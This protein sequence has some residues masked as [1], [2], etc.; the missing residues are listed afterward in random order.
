[1]DSFKKVMSGLALASMLLAGCTGMAAP[2]LTLTEAPSETPSAAPSTTAPTVIP[3]PTS[4]ATLAL[5]PT[6]TPNPEFSPPSIEL[7][8]ALSVESAEGRVLESVCL[9]TNATYTVAQTQ[10]PPPLDEVTRETLGAMGVEVRDPGQSCDADLI[11]HWKLTA[12]SDKYER[13][14][15]Y[16]TCFT[17][18]D[19]K[20]DVVLAIGETRLSATHAAESQ[21]KLSS[22]VC[23]QAD[24]V[25]FQE[26]WPVIIT[27]M[28]VN[29][30][31]TPSLYA[32]LDAP[33]MEH[34][35]K[36][37]VVN[38]FNA[39]EPLSR[40]IEDLI[41]RGERA[42]LTL[43]ALTSDTGAEIE[44][45]NALKTLGGP[46]V[47]AVLINALSKED[48]TAREIAALRLGLFVAHGEE[49]VDGAIP[50]LLYTMLKDPAPEVRWR[51]AESLGEAGVASETVIAALEEVASTDDELVVRSHAVGALAKLGANEKAM[52]F[53]PVLIDDLEGMEETA[54]GISVMAVLRQITGEDLRTAEA[55]RAWLV[56]QPNSGSD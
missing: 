29:L 11:I 15:E 26:V 14:G 56:D 1:M 4:T 30:W 2:D 48:S 46:E 16:Y 6:P 52:V 27:K 32:L 51:A 54:D 20:V 5:P 37:R 41:T 36:S 24:E 49:R 18:E 39:N 55:W 42:L 21:P 10:Y 9:T 7:P 50:A 3:S 22:Y 45:E 19:V 43:Y 13:E 34:S 44:A 23:P 40:Q 12:V 8:L 31:G 35:L 25:R 53:L 17:A 47:G 38:I 33:P 28:L